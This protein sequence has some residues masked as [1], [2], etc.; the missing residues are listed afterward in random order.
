MNDVK[1]KKFESAELTEEDIKALNI[2]P[3]D[4]VAYPMPSAKE[5]NEAGQF[6]LKMNLMASSSLD[7][8]LQ[9][10]MWNLY[11]KMDEYLHKD[12]DGASIKLAMA[13]EELKE[14][15]ITSNNPV[16]KDLPSEEKQK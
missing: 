7:L 5:I 10:I 13:L 16:F 3:R 6:L 15:I 14:Y 2:P 4:E 11:V 1:N 9:A 12:L 8:N